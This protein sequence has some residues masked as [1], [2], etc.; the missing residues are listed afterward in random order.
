MKPLKTTSLILV[1]LLAFAAIA[2]L[3]LGGF[4]PLFS[5]AF[6]I[7]FVYY[8][9]IYIALV[10]LSKKENTILKCIMV[11]LFLMPI[12]WGLF[13]PESLFNFLL[14]GVKMDFR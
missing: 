11:S 13:A 1:I 14:Q 8:L 6:G 12:L 3:F 4:M 5:I 2:A 9:F 10:L 7:L